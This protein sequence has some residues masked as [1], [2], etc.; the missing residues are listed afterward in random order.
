MNAIL[1]AGIAESGYKGRVD[2]FPTELA[3]LEEL[4][5]RAGR[6]DVVAVMSH[7]ER[8][9][10]FTWLQ[11]SAFKPVGVDRLRKLLGS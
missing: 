7:V 1:R 4:V 8:T 2:A 6:G 10:I 5:S 9:E 11:G 3:A